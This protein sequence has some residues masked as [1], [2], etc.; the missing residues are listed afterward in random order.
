MQD[1]IM[2]VL[3]SSLCSSFDGYQGYLKAQVKQV[4][5]WGCGTSMD[6][7]SPFLYEI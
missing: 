1:E 5:A 4:I 7:L 6:P 3:Y 2:Q